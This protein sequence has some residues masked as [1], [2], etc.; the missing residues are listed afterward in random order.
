M[1]VALNDS[2]G[3]AGNGFIMFKCGGCWRGHYFV[4]DTTL[5][6]SSGSFEGSGEKG[7]RKMGKGGLS[8]ECPRITLTG[9]KGAWLF[10]TGYEPRGAMQIDLSLHTHGVT[11]F[12]C[13]D[14]LVVC[15]IDITRHGIKRG[16]KVPIES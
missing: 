5:R 2:R 1:W 16:S 15:G 4:R 13:S 7:F 6:A 3:A 10:P 8:G 14:P 12:A 9:F 11:S